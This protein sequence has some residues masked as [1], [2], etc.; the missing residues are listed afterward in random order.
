ML[1]V[2]IKF[3][4]SILLLLVIVVQCF[5]TL[6]FLYSTLAVILHRVKYL[7]LS[8]YVVATFILSFSVIFICCYKY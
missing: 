2:N 6:R 1:V 5:K 7:A 3:Y 4:I 8:H